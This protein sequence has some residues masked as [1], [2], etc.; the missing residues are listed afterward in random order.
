MGRIL[1]LRAVRR[2]V[3]GKS[4]R[5]KKKAA[6]LPAKRG[7]GRRRPLERQLFFLGWLSRDV[8]VAWSDCFEIC[9]DVG[10]DFAE[11]PA[12]PAC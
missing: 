10:V 1:G 6:R 9:G 7:A 2:C 4:V 11:G 5:R 12:N 3:V 8:G